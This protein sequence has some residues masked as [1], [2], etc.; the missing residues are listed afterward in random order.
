MSKKNL[1]SGRDKELQEMAE[2]YEAA[3][4]ENR[5]RLVCRAS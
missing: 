4:A 5:T 3:K 1:L 2:Q